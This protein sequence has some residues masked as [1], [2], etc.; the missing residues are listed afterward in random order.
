MSIARIDLQLDEATLHTVFAELR[1]TNP[2]SFT[3]NASGHA[4]PNKNNAGTKMFRGM[5][6]PT[7]N[8]IEIGTQGASFSKESLFILTKH[9]RFTVLHELR[10]AWQRENWSES[11]QAIAAD[12][13]YESQPQEIDA[14]AWAEY[15]SPKYKSLVVVRRNQVGQ[16]GFGRLGQAARA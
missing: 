4:D 15:A 1:L 6:H 2:P 16:S 14:N 5:Y 13:D 3:L 12:G 9:L 7:N 8:H 10:H 11:E